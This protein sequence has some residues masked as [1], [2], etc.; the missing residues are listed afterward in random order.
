MNW[1]TYQF[2]FVIWNWDGICRGVKGE[3]QRGKGGAKE[4]Q[5]VR[6]GPATPLHRQK[7]KLEEGA[8]EEKRNIIFYTEGEDRCKW[9]ELMIEWDYEK[10]MIE[11]TWKRKLF[12]IFHWTLIYI[13]FEYVLTIYVDFIQIKILPITMREV[14]EILKFALA[15]TLSRFLG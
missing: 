2:F 14:E 13:I 12:R 1:C 9:E 5:I 4:G 8:W 11:A 3:G 10:I 7:S 6:R 15:K